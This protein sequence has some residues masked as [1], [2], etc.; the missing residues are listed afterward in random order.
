MKRWMQKYQDLNGWQETRHSL[1]VS[2]QPPSAR[3]IQMETLHTASV[4]TLS[5]PKA[6][7]WGS[8]SWTVRKLECHLLHY[9][10]SSVTDFTIAVFQIRCPILSPS[11]TNVK[12]PMYY[13]SKSPSQQ[14]QSLLI[15]KQTWLH[16]AIIP[17]LVVTSLLSYTGNF[18]SE[19]R[20]EVA[21]LCF[22]YS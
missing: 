9:V 11:Q 6:S 22:L 14:H 5:Q 20:H 13:F 2:T 17:S 15:S 21:A 19:T 7:S 10:Q 3:S 1:F 18:N 16:L 4:S 8:H 12:D